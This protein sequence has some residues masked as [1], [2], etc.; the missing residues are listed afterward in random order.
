[1]KSDPLLAAANDRGLLLESFA[2]KFNGTNFLFCFAHMENYLSVE[3]SSPLGLYYMK[4]KLSFY[5]KLT[6][7]SLMLEFIKVSTPISV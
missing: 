7:I 2:S 3:E 1:M 6:D 4:S 5:L